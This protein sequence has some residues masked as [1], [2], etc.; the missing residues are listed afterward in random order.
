MYRMVKLSDIHATA[1]ALPDAFS[2]LASTG[3]VRAEY[4]RIATAI[5]P[6]D[7]SFRSVSASQVDRFGALSS[8]AAQQWSP[9]LGICQS[10]GDMQLSSASGALALY[11]G[12]SL[13]PFEQAV[14]AAAEEASIRGPHGL[15]GGL[16][17]Q[18]TYEEAL[19]AAEAAQ[20]YHLPLGVVEQHRPRIETMADRL[21]IGSFAFGLEAD[22]WQYPAYLSAF[23][24]TAAMGEMLFRADR[25]T[26]SVT[27]SLLAVSAAGLPDFPD[28]ASS[29]RFMDAA[30]LLVP[31]WAVI[32]LPRFRRLTAQER[33]KKLK[34]LFKTKAPAKHVQKA[35]TLVH[36]AEA[37]LREVINHAM[38]S[39]YGPEWAASRLPL[40]DSKTLLGRAERRGGEPLEHADWHHYIEIMCHP[41]HFEAVFSSGFDDPNELR[42]LLV[43][44]KDLR[45]ASHHV[46]SFT[47]QHLL[48]LRLV[49]TTLETGLALLLPDV[50]PDGDWQG[51][52]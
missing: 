30:G 45:A 2:A 43:K 16:R 36:Q 23:S 52:A 22:Q 18:A 12:H 15:L 28:L 33:M 26:R 14:R 37:T 34:A 25:I 21:T 3:G 50:V 8:V 17:S 29:S 11:Q 49:W 48:D 6:D 46:H 4:E 47:P 38:T 24:R 51:Y 31:E 40:C 13:S 7:L 19:R 1:H 5:N 39:E 27:G 44:A 42:S 35:M 32:R 10:P 9:Y 41:A 20:N